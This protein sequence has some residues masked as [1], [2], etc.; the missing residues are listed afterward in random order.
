VNFVHFFARFLN[1]LILRNFARIKYS[2]KRAVFTLADNF[3]VHLKE[4]GIQGDATLK[5]NIDRALV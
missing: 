1:L 2:V 3:F 4:R 5:L